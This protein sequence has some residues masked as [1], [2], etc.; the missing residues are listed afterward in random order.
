MEVLQLEK[1]ILKYEKENKIKVDK[2]SYILYLDN[3]D[4]SV[5]DTDA[6]RTKWSCLGIIKYYTK[7]ELTI[8]ELD[9]HPQK[10]LY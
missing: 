5:I 3:R 4:V 2:L 8:I 7:R 1:D 10:D 6:L 9:Y